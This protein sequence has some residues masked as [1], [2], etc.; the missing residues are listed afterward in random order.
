MADVPRRVE[1]VDASILIDVI[2]VPMEAVD[3][4]RVLLEL[5]RKIDAGILLILPI[6]A[7]IETAQHV[8]RIENG[9][10]RRR[11][12]QSLEA[13]VQ[14][15]LSRLLPW[16]FVPT[17]WDEAFVADYLQQSP[18]HPLGLVESLGGKLAEAGDL[19][20]ISEYR[21]LRESFT[22]SLFDVDIWTHDTKLRSTIAWIRSSRA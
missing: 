14:E 10:L 8:Q 17:T 11:C 20:L 9:A 4:E 16:H 15:T 21:R 6:A 18:P 3:R 22:P 2:N 19:L 12:A 13:R 5:D 7:V 1:V